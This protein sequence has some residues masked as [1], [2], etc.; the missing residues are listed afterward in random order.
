MR[1]LFLISLICTLP[2]GCTTMSAANC[3]HADWYETG[4]Q[5]GV[6]GHPPERAL[7]YQSACVHY[8]IVPDR[9]AFANGWAAG[10]RASLAALSVPT[11]RPY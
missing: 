8:G 11:Q 5:A 10:A 9:E 6:N 1:K 3:L 4:Y 2:G 7:E